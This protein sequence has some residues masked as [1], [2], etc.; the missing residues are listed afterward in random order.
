MSGLR[1]GRH[2]SG[3]PFTKY[4]CFGARLGN[5]EGETMRSGSSFES[6]CQ[7]AGASLSRREGPRSQCGYELSLH[8]LPEAITHSAERFAKRGGAF[9]LARGEHGEISVLAFAADER[10]ERGKLLRLAAVPPFGGECLGGN[11]QN[12]QGPLPI[13]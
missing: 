5:R 4:T 6:G 11:A 12:V 9:A 1:N 7:V 13:K 3:A 10:L 2:S 8:V